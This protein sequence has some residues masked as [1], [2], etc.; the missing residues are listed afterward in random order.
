M[1]LLCLSLS[2]LEI[3]L[4]ATVFL[5][6]FT[7]WALT[8]HNTCSY[9][10]E[11]PGTILEMLSALVGS[12]HGSLQHGN[13]LRLVRDAAFFD[14][15]E[16]EL[17]SATASVHLETYLWRPGKASDRVVRALCAAS[18]R[19]VQVRILADAHGAYWFD[20]TDKRRLRAAGC[21]FKIFHRWIPKNMGRF[22]VRD[23]RKL[24]VV[25]G[26]RALI[27]GHCLTDRWL[28]DEPDKPRYRDLSVHVSGPVV[29]SLQSAF[30]ENWQERT[31]ELFT[32][33]TTYPELEPVGDSTAHLAYLR[34]DGCPSS[35]QIL[36]HL[37]IA[38]AKQRIR[39]QN[40]YFLPDKGGADALIRAVARGVD[41][42]IMTP[43]PAASDSPYVQRAAHH[44]YH[45][46]LSG[47]VRIHEFQPT[48][49]HQ[50]VIT[51]DGIWAG[52]GSSNF[53]DRSFKINDEVTMGIA[54]ASIVREL[55][56]EFDADLEHCRECSLSEIKRRPF[57]KRIVDAILYQLS[58]Q[59]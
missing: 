37:A 42:Q 38:Y 36:H 58:E 35:V 10:G 57:Y 30:L 49:L 1:N 19:G 33:R 18:S 50:K 22:N 12:T 56:A 31:A 28:L 34:P 25:D 14:E 43:S 20:P 45:R 48:L 9:E 40:P 24:V 2:W 47:G 54:D 13:R 44:M 23:H 46:L 3:S 53:D 26:S 41:V 55:E 15:V 39:I 17:A 6:G 7:V 21:Q 52:I 51:I 11:P 5:L 16:R 27:G 4:G 59:L 29:A 32:D 8:R